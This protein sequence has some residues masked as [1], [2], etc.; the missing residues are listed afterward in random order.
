MEKNGSTAQGHKG[1]R[2]VKVLNELLA[3]IFYC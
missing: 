1:A 2:A 3:A